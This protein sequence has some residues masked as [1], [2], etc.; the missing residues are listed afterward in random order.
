MAPMADIEGLKVKLFLDGAELR[1]IRAM[2]ADPIIR[3]FTTNPSLMRKAGVRDY[4]AFARGALAA[5][6]EK[7]ISFEV[8][9][10]DLP[11]MEREARV[12]AGWGGC[13][14]VK[15]PIT[16]T[17]GDST[18]PLI[19]RLSSDGL[20]LN[21][22][23]VLTLDQVR[24]ACAALA[25]RA[26]AIISVFAGRIADTG[27]DPAP[28]MRAAARLL[29]RRPNVELLWA[30][31][32]EL[33]NI[34]QAEACGCHIITATADLLGKLP[35]VGRDLAAYSLE[36]VKMF[37]ADASASGLSLSEPAPRAA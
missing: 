24:V 8:F 3:G 19:R 7:P 29:R 34:F 2:A 12:I 22:T 9:A 17:S 4:E 21:V 30:S 36:T 25:P 5:V 14:Y 11:A 23:A 33:L 15:L 18:A 26:Q 28:I 6:G 27:V 1:V 35:L 31:P 16:T 10:D 20:A 13:A 32:R 37:Y